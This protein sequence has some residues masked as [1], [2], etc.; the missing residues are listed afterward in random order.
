MIK[1]IDKYIKGYIQT[2]SGSDS[3]S[4]WCKAKGFEKK[5]SKKLCKKFGS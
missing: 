2:V 3:S 4:E 1:N 5:T